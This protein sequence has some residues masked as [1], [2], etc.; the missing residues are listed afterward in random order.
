MAA[1]KWSKETRE[2]KKV[3]A[4]ELRIEGR[5]FSQIAKQLGCAKSTANDLYSDALAD[6]RPH[7]NATEYRNLQLVEI[8]RTKSVVSLAIGELMRSGEAPSS[9]ELEVLSRSLVRLQERE[10]KLLGFDYYLDREI[11]AAEK[12]SH[13]IDDKIEGFLREFDVT[14]TNLQRENSWLKKEFS[15][16]TG[17]PE[18]DTLSYY[19]DGEYLD[20]DSWSEQLKA[21]SGS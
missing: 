17:Q 8:R 15:K 13:E 10:A 9:S 12:K 1:A 7:E 16:V 19:N 4:L 20:F 2:Q 21:G 6:I 11:A 18:L 5:T 14:Q 3:E